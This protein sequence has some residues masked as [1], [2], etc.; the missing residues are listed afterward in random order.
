MKY[1]IR[2]SQVEIFG[3]YLEYYIEY[4]DRLDEACPIHYKNCIILH[5]DEE[6][7]VL[8]VMKEGEVYY[9]GELIYRDIFAE[10]ITLQEAAT[11]WGFD[12]STLRHAIAKGKF[13]KYEYKKSGK[14]WLIKKSAMERVYGV[15]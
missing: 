8:D 11:L 15:C 2:G 13:K 7:I 9:E 12:S 10:I 14:V 4:E 3:N 6:S 5:I 1:E